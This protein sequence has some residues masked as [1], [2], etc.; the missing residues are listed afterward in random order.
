M[1]NLQLTTAIIWSQC[2]GQFCSGQ[3][4]GYI[5]ISLSSF[6]TTWGQLLR[7]SMASAKKLG[8]IL[9][10]LLLKRVA[11]C[12]LHSWA[13]CAFLRATLLVALPWLPRGGNQLI[14]PSEQLVSLITINIHFI[15]WCVCV[16]VCLHARAQE[17]FLSFNL[18]FARLYGIT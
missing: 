3:S 2:H 7:K 9:K 10:A 15:C 14:W 17:L 1:E 18:D 4:D 13:A 6:T 11:N 8:W 5:W 12:I 16:C